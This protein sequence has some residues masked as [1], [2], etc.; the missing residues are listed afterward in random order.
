MIGLCRTVVL[1]E[2]LLDIGKR[3]RL[4]F[5]GNARRVGTD[6]GDEGDMPLPFDVHTL[7]EVLRHEHGL[8]RGV[9][10]LVGSVLL[11][12][13]RREG[14]GSV[15]ARHALL[16]GRDGIIARRKR[17]EHGVRLLLAAHFELFIVELFERRLEGENF[18]SL[19]CNSA[20]IVQYSSGLNAWISRSRSTTSLSATDCTRPAESPLCNLL[21]RSGESL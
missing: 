21:L 15:R 5:V 16:D 1:A 19:S 14:R 20:V 2:A 12:G 6:V 11:Q 4:R 8:G 9:A 7:V 17:P 18:F 3:R 13:A 10:E